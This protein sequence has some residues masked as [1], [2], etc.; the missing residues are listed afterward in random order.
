MITGENNS[1]ETS[2]TSNTTFN[3]NIKNKLS[4]RQLSFKIERQLVESTI[5]KIVQEEIQ[6]ANELAKKGINHIFFKTLVFIYN[7]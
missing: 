6:K 3:E 5:Q 7:L 4:E 1:D 2:L